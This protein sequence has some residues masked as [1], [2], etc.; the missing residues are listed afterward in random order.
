MKLFL[1]LSLFLTIETHAETFALVGDVGFSPKQT[2]S[3]RSSL[4]K[5]KIKNL[6][7]PGD[8]IYDE[9]SSYEA[10][11][12]PW[13]K[14]GFEFS[15]VAI[16]N[17]TLGYSKEVDYF[18]MPAEFF[19]VERGPAHFMVL[20]SDNVSTVDAQMTWLEKSLAQNKKK[21]QILVYH[22]SSFTVTQFHNWKEKE[23]FQRKLRKIL[24]KFKSKISLV[25]V[26]HDHVAT[27]Y[28]AND[29][30]VVVSGAGVEARPL[31]KSNYKED[32]WQ[33]KSEYIYS[34]VLYWVRADISEE[35]IWLNF[36]NIP[37]DK[38]TCSVEI[39]H[40]PK[41]RDLRVGNN[42]KSGKRSDSK[43]VYSWP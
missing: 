22:H 27:L 7:I 36:V 21:Y 11:W 1:A 35:S 13:K 5:S 26:G 38:V 25:I 41:G 8:N 28:T 19:S 20:N 3:L 23:N 32:G 6:I 16:G 14:Q 17:H 10:V 34:K 30:P 9:S 24:D 31:V 37:K 42:C 39:V 40:S 29:I 2:E 18:K 15:I 12:G 4:L 33:I 43:L